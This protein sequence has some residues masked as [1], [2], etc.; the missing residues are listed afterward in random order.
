[1]TAMVRFCGL[2][3]PMRPQFL[4][5]LR[6]FKLQLWPQDCQN[7]AVWGPPHAAAISPTVMVAVLSVMASVNLPQYGYGRM[8]KKPMR[9]Y[10][11]Y[12]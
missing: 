6:H 3:D 12:Y 4:L 7:L 2:M 11:A 8:T 1:M 5:R 10:T 9:S